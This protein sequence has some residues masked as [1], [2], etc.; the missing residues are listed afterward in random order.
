MNVGQ[1]PD[2]VTTKQVKNDGFLVS[3]F[4]LICILLYYYSIINEYIIKLW[5]SVMGLGTQSKVLTKTS[6]RDGIHYTFGKTKWSEKSV[7]FFIG[8]MRLR[9]KEISQV[10]FHKRFLILVVKLIVVSGY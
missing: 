10:V 9:A 3:V 7:H 4:E 5:G 2:L 1:R 6:N 8:K